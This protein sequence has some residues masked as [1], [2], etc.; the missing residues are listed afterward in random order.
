MVKFKNRL[1]K[2]K[3]MFSIY[4]KDNEIIIFYPITTDGEFCRK[5]KIKTNFSDLE[6]Q[7]AKSELG[8]YKNIINALE[9]E[10][11]KDVKNQF[12][13]RIEEPLKYMYDIKIGRKIYYHCDAEEKMGKNFFARYILSSCS[14]E[15]YLKMYFEKY[16]KMY[17][18]VDQ[19]YVYML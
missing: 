15:E 16:L 11:W 17:S 10:N 19:I 6:I 5:I 9:R 14:F 2:Y 7:T 8:Y 3:E 12:L 4:Q 13:K 1:N 18:D